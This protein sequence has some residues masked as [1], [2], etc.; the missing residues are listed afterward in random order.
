MLSRITIIEIEHYPLPTGLGHGLTMRK[1]SREDLLTAARE[2]PAQLSLA[3]VDDAL[4]RGDYC[5]AAF[6][7]SRMVAWAWASFDTA[8][9]DDG[10]WVKVEPPYSYGYKWYTKPEYRGQG[11]I[12]QLAIFRDKL[13]AE[14][15]ITHN[16]GF[17]ETHNYASW[18]TN[19][20]LHTQFVGYAGYFRLL[21]KSYP[22]RTP[23]VVK[24]TFRFYRESP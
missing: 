11:I 5:A 14:T 7:G 2:N 3:F 6:D 23:G 16:V 4:A 9:H 1:A 19:Q 24:H 10:L 8:P 18:Q 13:G 22:F 17:T 15:G 12:G 21:G 20:R